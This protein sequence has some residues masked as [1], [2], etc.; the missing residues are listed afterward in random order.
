[1]SQPVS[2]LPSCLW[3]SNAPRCWSTHTLMHR[4]VASAT[5]GPTVSKAAAKTHEEALSSRFGSSP[6]VDL[7]A[8]GSRLL[9][10]LRKHQPGFRSSCT[11][12]VL[13]SGSAWGWG[14]KGTGTQGHPSSPAASAPFSPPT[15]G[16]P[17]EPYPE[18]GKP[19][20]GHQLQWLNPGLLSPVL[21]PARSGDGGCPCEPCIPGCS[22]SRPAPQ[23]RVPVRSRFSSHPTPGP[24]G[25]RGG[26]SAPHSSARDVTHPQAGASRQVPFTLD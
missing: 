22:D 20:Q 15:V 6:E 25:L 19:A 1:M 5:C 23:A 24:P 11:S 14:E 17:F 7:L 26:E 13:L 12:Q 3:L 18:V 8:Q 16:L 10:F 9:V 21:W 4:H 2:V